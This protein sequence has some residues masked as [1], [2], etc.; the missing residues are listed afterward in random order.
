MDYFV[1]TSSAPEGGVIDAYPPGSPAEWKFD[2]GVSLARQF[3]KGAA[4]TFSKSFPDFRKLYDFQANI[5]NAFVVSPQARQLMEGLGVANAEFL[6]VAIKDH[7]GA[8]VAPDYAFMNL[9]GAEDAIDMEKSEYKLNPI[10]KEQIGRLKKLVL[11]PS[12]IPPEAKMFRCSKQRR[13]VL[14]REDVRAAFTQAGLTG[15]KTYP[16]QGWNGL[17]L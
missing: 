3:P 1:L 11:K 7:S 8:T 13:L 14:I 4:V 6:P 5:L 15:W 16:A 12:S 9:V 2:E 17:E 10:N